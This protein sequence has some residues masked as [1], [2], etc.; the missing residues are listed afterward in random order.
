MGL[1]TTLFAVLLVIVTTWRNRK[2]ADLDGKEYTPFGLSDVREYV[3][4]VFREL[5][6][7]LKKH[8]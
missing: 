4:D 7:K 2:I 1:K 6:K 8:Q 5:G 3:P